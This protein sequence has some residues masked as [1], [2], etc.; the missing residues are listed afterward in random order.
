VLKVEAAWFLV[1]RSFEEHLIERDQ[2]LRLEAVLKLCDPQTVEHNI[3]RFGRIIPAGLF[4][5]TNLAEE[6]VAA[7]I[8]AWPS[9]RDR[10]RESI[11]TA[12]DRVIGE[13]RDRAH[14][15][16]AVDA[17]A[18]YLAERPSHMSDAE[19]RKRVRAFKWAR[20]QL[21]ITSSRSLLGEELD[22]LNDV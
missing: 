21:G 16:G 7:I 17:Y 10:A 9:L 6:L 4:L 3:D 13:A 18:G 15:E 8:A 1:Q 12:I 5:S 11:A 19:K 22:L 20:R 2:F 14:K